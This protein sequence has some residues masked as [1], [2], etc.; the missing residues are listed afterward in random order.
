MVK[1]VKKLNQADIEKALVD[2]MKSLSW[3]M[4]MNIDLDE[5]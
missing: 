3:E 4:F 5:Q 2:T 1:K